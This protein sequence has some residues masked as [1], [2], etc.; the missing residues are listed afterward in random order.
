LYEN[1]PSWK[2]VNYALKT[3]N[4]EEEKII[5]FKRNPERK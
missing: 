5:H 3:K 2:F 1:Y 4:G